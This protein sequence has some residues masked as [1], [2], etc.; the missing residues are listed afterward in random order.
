MSTSVSTV[1]PFLCARAHLSLPWTLA[2][3]RGRQGKHGLAKSKV[4]V[5]VQGTP[6]VRDRVAESRRGCHVSWFPRGQK[7]VPEL[8]M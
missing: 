6:C 8:L 1:V 3:G 7:P 2:S 4:K 5:E